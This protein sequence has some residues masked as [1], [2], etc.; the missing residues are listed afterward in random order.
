MKGR[1]FGVS[2]LALV[3]LACACG[4]AVA[5]PAWLAPEGPFG[6]SEG[7]SATATMSPDGTV[8][9]AQLRPTAGNEG[10]LEVRTRPPGGAFG[11]TETIDAP[12]SSFVAPLLVAGREGSVAVLYGRVSGGVW[13]S[14]RPAGGS[15][16]APR[17]LA[18]G[19]SVSPSTV[20]LDAGRLWFVY[21]TGT[22][23]AASTLGPTG[24]ATG[25]TIDTAPAGYT[26]MQASLGLSTD[27][28]LRV[29]YAFGTMANLS[30]PNCSQKSVLREADGGA[31]GFAAPATLAT[32]EA[33]GPPITPCSLVGGETM[34]APHLATTS[35]GATT[36][37]YETHQVSG[38]SSTAWARFRPAGGAWPAPASSAEKIATV[39]SFPTLS[40]TGAGPV[41]VA[42][43]ATQIAPSS[44]A[45]SSRNPDGSWGPLQPLAGSESSAPA[46][47][48]SSPDGT[49]VVA[50]KQN[51]SPYRIAAAVRSPAGAI[52][53]PTFVSPPADAFTRFGGIGIDDE[54][55]AVVGWSAHVGGSPSAGFRAEVAGYDGA[56]PR[57]TSLDVP[58]SGVAGQS[59]GFAASAVDVWSPVGPPSWDF[60]D[61]GSASGA[62]VSHSFGP[63]SYTVSAAV[64]DALGNTNSASRPLAISPAPAPGA[65]AGGSDTT[66]PKLTKVALK[67]KKVKRGKAVKLSFALSE[68]AALRVT[69]ARGAKGVKRGRKCVKAQPKAQGKAKPCRRFVTVKTLGGKFGAGAGSLALPKTLAVGAYKI[70]AVATDAAGNGSTP[71]SATLTVVPAPHH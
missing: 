69:L 43:I 58:A 59:L 23:F 2:V 45:L 67:P 52:S 49:T 64:T 6:E 7:Q 10:A 53:P 61:G 48:A 38:S 56:G 11:A 8:T 47:L 12:V 60:G 36:V 9:A 65:T 51:T 20:V 16:G 55:N 17:L 24:S 63:G 26:P 34:A 22:T 19:G 35:D 18:A 21:G 14:I 41:P 29:A 1:I 28:Q 50:W 4:S 66:P 44:V 3:A 5:A 37:I 70:T 42:A 30:E 71:V 33:N 13:A 15:F 68:A 62:A 27:G 31:F 57:I 32:V 46:Y 40:I 25:S 39:S 54:G